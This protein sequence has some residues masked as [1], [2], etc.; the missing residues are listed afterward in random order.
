[1]QLG[2]HDSEDRLTHCSLFS[3]AWGFLLLTAKFKNTQL[4]YPFVTM[5]KRKYWVQGDSFE[6]DWRWSGFLFGA[7]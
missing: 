3:E 5:A 7:S 1:M 4:S 6:Q 2:Y